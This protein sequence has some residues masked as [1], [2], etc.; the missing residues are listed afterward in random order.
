SGSDV[1]ACSFSRPELLSALY[2]CGLRYVGFLEELSRRVGAQSDDDLALLRLFA[3]RARA[4]LA[5]VTLPAQ[6]RLDPTGDGARMLREICADPAATAPRLVYA[7]WL[8]SHGDARGE[9]I[10]LQCAAPEQ[11]EAAAER[12]RDLIERHRSDWLGDLADLDGV[13]WD[14]G[15]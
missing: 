1:P 10:V 14:R 5:R 8:L 9:L 12:E 15:F 7:D 11:A 4:A 13:G 6:G 2:A 3:E